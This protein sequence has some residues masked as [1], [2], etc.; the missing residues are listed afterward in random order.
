MFELSFLKKYLTPRRKQ[1]SVSLISLLSTAVITLVVWLVSL[2]LSITEGIEQGWLNKMTA[3]N[4]PLRIHPTE[5]YFS[6]YYYNIDKYSSGANYL[7][8]TIGEKARALIS[9]PYNPRFDAQLPRLMTRP[10]KDHSGALRDPVKGIYGA[11]EKLK[12][13]WPDLRYQDAEVSG[14]LFKLEM[15]RKNSHSLEGTEMMRQLTNVT[16]LT[17]FSEKNPHLKQLI[18]PITADDISQLLYMAKREEDQERASQIFD[19]VNIESLH[20]EG[21]IWKLPKRL[22][23]KGSR[24]QASPYFHGGSITHITIPTTSGEGQEGELY[25]DSDGLHFIGMEGQSIPIGEEIPLFAMGKLELNVIETF[26]GPFFEI[27]G[28]LQGIPVS[29]TI[30][31]E[32]LAIGSVSLK[33]TLSGS[34]PPWVHLDVEGI[35][36]LPQSHFRHGVL[37]PKSYLDTGVKV[38]DEGTLSYSGQTTLGTKELRLPIFIAGFYDPGIMPVGNKC[39]L[40]PS[41]ITKAVS[42][43]EGAYAID[44]T[45]ANGIQVWFSSLSDAPEIKTELLSQ[46]AE[47][48]LD[49]YWQVETFREFDFAR[50]L[51]QQFSSD[52]YLFTLVGILILLVACT[53]IISLLVLLVSDKKKEIGILRAMG[54]KRASIAGIFASAGGLIGLISCSLGIFLAYITLQHIDGLVGLLS[55]LQGHE[56]LNPQFFGSSLPK[57]LSP[58]ALWFAALIT[59]LLSLA[60]GLIPAIK[61]AKMDPCDTLRSE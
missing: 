1:L 25:T 11:L 36:T 38:G 41:S 34:S 57:T 20:P 50:D 8:K 30:P 12:Q 29:G 40:V 18:L 43:S 2:F 24:F 10:D 26:P 5:E 48:G 6:S 4:A 35:P 31:Y 56:A 3:L 13:E 16:Y 27:K 37:A 21:E 46:L 52:K 39:L 14:A 61:A 9:D 51:L 54:A 45:L 55:A 53:N 58:R 7:A 19:A 42:V 59:P 49:K 47:A 15:I 17:S 60:S 32:G 33:P 22:L 23:K 44:R 28:R